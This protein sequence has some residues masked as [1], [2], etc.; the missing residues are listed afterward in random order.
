M[1][2]PKDSE[3]VCVEGWNEALYHQAL[4][5]VDEKRRVAF[6]SEEERVSADPRVKI[7]HL[8]SPLQKEG[9]LKKIAWSAVQRN[10]TAIGAPA[11]QEKIG[12][13]H[14]AANMILSEAADW[15]VKVLKNARANAKPYRRGMDLKGAFAG[16]PALI[17]GAGPS[18]E[19][20]GHLLREF[21][22]KALIFAGGSA[23]NVIDVEPHFAAA[24]DPEAP[25]RQFKMQP[26]SE[27]PFCYQSR[28][29]AENFSLV[30]GE[31]LLFPD[32]SS[33]AIN[34]L[35]GEEAFDSGWTVGN[36]STAIALHLGCSPIIFVG[37][38]FCYVQNRKYAQIHA[39]LPKGLVQAGEYLTQRDWLM[40]AK[41]TEALYPHRRD[42]VNAT[43]GG[44]LQLPA[45]TL[46]TVLGRC[47]A[48]WDLRK[49]VH[50]AIQKLPLKKPLLRWK[51]WDASLRRL[52]KG[53]EHPE[54][55]IVYQKLLEPLWQIWKPLFEREMG[56]IELHQMLFFQQ[57]LEEHGSL[58]L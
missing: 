21:E 23:L 27:T 31:R 48:E 58:V 42:F 28:M 4:D 1:Q 12:E 9:F 44:L 50:E 32:S 46:E 10:M 24:L 38:D 11:F 17:V 26:F 55:E 3:F 51:Q 52:K 54:Q 33:D 37:M 16:V 22:R 20:N 8:E 41:W 25:Y 7:Y 56:K 39:D 13:C 6:L 30:H 15:G 29:S 36:F 49:R 47:T 19:K 34:W 43:E 53:T 5:W 40:A 57:V 2:W 45:A 35:Y 14:L 18:L